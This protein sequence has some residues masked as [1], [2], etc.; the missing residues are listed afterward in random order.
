MRP[1][2]REAFVPLT[3]SFEGGYIGW[4]FPDVKGLV[5]TGFGLL[6]DPVALA[7]ALPWRRKDGSLATAGEIV[8]DFANVKNF[9]DA[10]RLG[11]LSV[12]NIAKLHLDTDGLDQ[13]FKG[14]LAQNE[15]TLREG[16]PDWDEWC[17]DA[18]LATM[19]LAWA[20]GA[21]FWS[22]EAPPGQ[23]FPKCTAALRARDYKA[24]SVECFLDEEDVISGL[25]PRN[26]A[27]RML[28][29]NAN[30]VEGTGLDPAVLHYPRDLTVSEF[31]R[32]APTLPDLGID[33][34]SDPPTRLVHPWHFTE[35]AAGPGLAPAP[36]ETAPSV[37]G[38]ESEKA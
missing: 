28:F 23:Y 38:S 29:R 10:P 12:K 8:A 20:V 1:A 25:H 15:A 13:A 19:S 4:M 9:P 24:A 27:N 14:K 33:P 16:F 2:A 31:D 3:V 5:S 37:D 17:A 18:Q 30:V 36:S 26:V 34:D 32:E 11:H 7:L 35:E 6:L 21:A 22:P